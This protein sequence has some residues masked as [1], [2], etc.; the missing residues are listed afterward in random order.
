MSNLISINGTISNL[1][2][3]KIPATDRGFLFADNVFETLVAFEGKVLNLSKHIERLR[4]SAENMQIPIPWGD[5]ELEFELKSMAEQTSHTKGFL[6]LVVTRGSGFGISFGDDITPNKYIYSLPANMDPD[7]V[8]QTGIALKRKKTNSTLRGPAV[9]TGN[10]LTSIV[11][12]NKAKTEGY[13]D[14]LWVNGESEITEASTANIFF[15]GRY[16]DEVEI[17]T[18]SLFSG[19]L[20]GITRSTIMSLLAK[21]RIRV[22]ERVVYDEEIPRFDE[23]FIC[24]TVRGLVPVSKISEHKLH[25]TRPSAVFHHIHRLYMT[26]AEVE[27]GHRVDWNTGK[28]V[29]KKEV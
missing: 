5:E 19:L 29:I 23:A 10:Y 3:A 24:S 22:E 27:L 11:A 2:D 14:I 6:R 26:W 8:Q 20:N 18:P 13:H 4:T 16:G 12:I 1:E 15:I 21:A 7:W 25:T 28:K 9:K 17:V